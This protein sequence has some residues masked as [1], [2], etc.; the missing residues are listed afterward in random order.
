MLN[1]EQETQR[2]LADYRDHTEKLMAELSSRGEIIKR[3]LDEV[4]ELRQINAQ[5][6]G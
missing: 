3:L 6:R 4:E 2:L 1:I 5:L